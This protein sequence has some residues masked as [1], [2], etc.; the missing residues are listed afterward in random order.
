MSAWRKAT[1][2]TPRS[3][4]RARPVELIR[5]DVDP[6][7]LPVRGPLS[8]AEGDRART[9]ATVEDPAGR[10]DVMAEEGTRALRGAKTQVRQRPFLVPNG[11]GALSRHLVP[12][13]GAWLPPNVAAMTRRTSVAH[14]EGHHVTSCILHGDGHRPP[15]GDGFAPLQ[16]VRRELQAWVP[17]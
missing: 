5:A 16:L 12:L 14:D 15:V 3:R 8:K 17:A 11:V 6:D 10:S 2:F 4:A 1:F 13:V 7:R 9:A